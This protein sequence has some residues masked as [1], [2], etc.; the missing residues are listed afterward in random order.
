MNLTELRELLT[1]ISFVLGAFKSTPEG[2][3]RRA[4]IRMQKDIEQWREDR[5]KFIKDLQKDRDK[6]RITEDQLTEKLNTWDIHNPEP[7]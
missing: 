6:G 5:Y 4:A 2:R 1:F 7:K 3:K